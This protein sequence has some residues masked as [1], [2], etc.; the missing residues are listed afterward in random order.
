MSARE[1]EWSWSTTPSCASSNTFHRRASPLAPRGGNGSWV[2]ST[3][4]AARSSTSGPCRISSTTTM[5][6]R[7]PSA[8]AV[9]SPATT[10]YRTNRRHRRPMSSPP[11]GS[12]RRPRCHPASPPREQ[13]A[14][15]GGIHRLRDGL[16][17]QSR[18]TGPPRLRQLVRVG[19]NYSH[20]F[21][22]SVILMVSSF[23]YILIFSMTVFTNW[24]KH[25]WHKLSFN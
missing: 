6:Y 21:S 11:P 7:Q 24:F 15:F 18:R 22:L 1:T 19:H 12:P 3:L 20:L 2:R 25:S 17:C 10:W 13:L 14:V 9:R 16:S 4:S 23:N 8:P 5:R